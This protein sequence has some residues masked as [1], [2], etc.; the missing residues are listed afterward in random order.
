MLSD[1]RPGSLHVWF[2]AE[3]LFPSS[4]IILLMS[5][6]S[7][8]LLRKVPQRT[9]IFCSAKEPITEKNNKRKINIQTQVRVMG[10]LAVLFFSLQ[11]FLALFLNFYICLLPVFCTQ[12]HLPGE[13]PGSSIVA[14]SQQETSL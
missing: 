6:S 5:L 1:H 12:C 13:T 8:I 7:A 10:F 2:H 9:E 3:S 14:L 4:Q 11:T